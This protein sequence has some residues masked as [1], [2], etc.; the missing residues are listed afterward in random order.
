VRA[1]RID[2]HERRESCGRRKRKGRDRKKTIF[3]GF[4]RYIFWKGTLKQ[5]F[6]AQRRQGCN[7]LGKTVFQCPLYMY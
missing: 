7:I 1:T 6:S 5:F 2:A 3:K 4:F